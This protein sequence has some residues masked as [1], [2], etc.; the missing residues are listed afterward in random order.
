MVVT[1]LQ[2]KNVK[3]GYCYFCDVNLA[4]NFAYK[5]SKREQNTLGIELAE[6]VSFCSQKCL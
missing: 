5:L 4:G 3:T 1:P 6:G 2:Q